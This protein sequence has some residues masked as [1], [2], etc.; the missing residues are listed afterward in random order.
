[1]MIFVRRLVMKNKNLNAMS[2]KQ[3]N[4]RNNNKKIEGYCV[5]LVLCS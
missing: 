1:M 3:K 4:G 2:S 5:D